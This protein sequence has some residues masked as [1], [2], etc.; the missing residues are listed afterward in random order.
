MRDSG[1]ELEEFAEYVKEV[2]N[3]DDDL[4]RMNVRDCDLYRRLA[5]EYDNIDKLID[6]L[7]LKADLHE[8]IKECLA[9]EWE[10]LRTK[11]LGSDWTDEKL[12][13]CLCFRVSLSKDDRYKRFNFRYGSDEMTKLALEVIRSKPHDEKEVFAAEKDKYTKRHSGYSGQTVETKRT[14]GGNTNAVPTKRRLRD[15]LNDEDS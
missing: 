5:K 6:Q 15:R 1:N 8:F 3:T 9:K 4:G 11:H 2:A 10:D 13:G 7:F 12:A 14:N